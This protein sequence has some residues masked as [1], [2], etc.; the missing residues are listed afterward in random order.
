MFLNIF[1]F[2]FV[3]LHLIVLNSLL[4]FQTKFTQIFLIS[5]TT[6]NNNLTLPPFLPYSNHPHLK[7]KLNLPETF[8]HQ[9]TYLFNHSH[10]SMTL[11]T[12][13]SFLLSISTK[14]STLGSDSMKL[15]KKIEQESKFKEDNINVLKNLKK[16]K[17]TKQSDDDEKETALTQTQ[18]QEQELNQNQGVLLTSETLNPPLSKALEENKEVMVPKQVLNRYKELVAS[19]N[20]YSGKYRSAI[21]ELESLF[22]NIEME[23]D[24]KKEK[25]KSDGNEGSERLDLRIIEVGNDKKEDK[26]DDN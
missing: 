14:M 11:I 16:N 13:F 22:K 6:P 12:F 26:N 23:K 25:K 21:R 24:K 1:L 9:K 2:L 20:D 18:S 5:V 17:I 7:H 10:S 8:Y 4:T 19:L 15:I 3:F